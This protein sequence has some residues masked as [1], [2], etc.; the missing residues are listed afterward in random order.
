MQKLRARSGLGPLHQRKTGAISFT[1]R[2][3][4][5]QKKR[6]KNERERSRKTVSS[7]SPRWWKVE[8][9]QVLVSAACF[10]LALA[11]CDGNGSDSTSTATPSAPAAAPQSLEATAAL[12]AKSTSIPLPM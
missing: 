12:A 1:G 2:A 7:I 11:A 9:S 8:T 10:S 4:N 3:G 6:H 5:M